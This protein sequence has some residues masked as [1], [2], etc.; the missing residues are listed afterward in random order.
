MNLLAKRAGLVLAASVLFL[1]SCDDDSFLLG[2]KGKPR[3]QGAY[4][5][6]K[7][8]GTR[9]SV[10]L[11][12]SVVTDQYSLST[13]PP[14]GVAFPVAGYRYMLGEYNDPEFG[15]VRSE[16][17]AQFQPSSSPAPYFNTANE[18]LV[19][20]SVTVQLLFDYYVYGPEEDMSERIAVYEMS[21]AIY[22]L[23]DTLS[24]FARYFNY[25]TTLYSATPLAELS[26]DMKQLVYDL[27]NDAGRDSSFYL[28]GTI[29]SKLDDDD[30]PGWV[31]AK[32]LFLYVNSTGDSALV[33]ANAR[34]F[35]NQFYGLAFIPTQSNRIL[36]FNPLHGTSQVTMHY[37]ST[38]PARDSLTL[39]FYFTPYPYS[40]ANGF[41]NITTT[42][43]G[44]L[45]GLTEPYVP[46][47]P[48]S[49]KRYIQDGSAVITELD[50]SD[51]YS[52]IDTIDNIIINS[53]ELSVALIDPPAGIGPPASLY[54]RIMKETSDN[55]IVP[56]DMAVD[57][58]SVKMIE[59]FSSVFTDLTS[60]VISSELSSQS[61]L[62]LSYDRNSG[63]Y[64]GY[65]TMFF[66]KLFDNKD[67]PE[68]NIEHIGL[69][70]A[71]APL[72]TEIP[73]RSS[74]VPVLRTS[75]GNEV[76]RAVFNSSG[77]KLKLYYT[78]PNLPNLE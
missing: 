67:K 8:E 26:F 13:D 19:L 41:N 68:Y 71:T 4:H 3:Y 75:V 51:F 14:P 62:V 6:I 54:G 30:A 10:L 22:E 72:Y 44:D 40:N 58:D 60:F 69:Y 33:G 64:S 43:T 46:Y 35:R 74:T 20:D 37:Q 45:A 76:N 2:I 11:L 32:R 52:F 70:P 61:P 16:L 39:S 21:E 31:F 24:V 63:K 57:E 56:L 38:N 5:E 27:A 55:K 48:P 78:I 9:S 53:A 36:G 18:P 73:G 66:Q 65:A 77:I 7:F 49:G 34:E 29:G 23:A 12:D 42:R 1:L 47:S 59:F 15:T 28:K 17:F 25:S 50:L